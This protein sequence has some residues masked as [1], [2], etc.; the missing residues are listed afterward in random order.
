MGMIRTC[1]PSAKLEND[2]YDWWKR[3]ESK[4]EWSKTNKAKAI[5]FG[6][7]ITHFW[8]KE[9]NIN[10]GEDSWDEFFAGKDVLN[11][12]YGFDRIQNVLWHIEAGEVDHQEPAVIVVNIG[13]N[14]L[15]SSGNYPGDNVEDTAEGIRFLTEKL[16]EKFPSAHIVVMEILPRGGNVFEKVKSTNAIL[17]KT[18][19][20]LPYA[21]LID[22]SAAFLDA[23][24]NPDPQFFKKDMCHLCR[25]GYMVWYGAIKDI[26][27]KYL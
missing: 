7:S 13:T 16:H 3:H 18:I 14:N 5:F 2:A 10:Y 12:G 23:D 6:D 19:P 9:D 11:M 22:A 4:K 21:Q 26:L 17:K 27:A 20:L 1:I 24:G 15:T 25:K 8:S